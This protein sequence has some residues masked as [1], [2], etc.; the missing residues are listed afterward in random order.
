MCVSCILFSASFPCYFLHHLFR[1]FLSVSLFSWKRI[2]HCC[3]QFI[4]CSEFQVTLRPIC[5]YGAS[6]CVCKCSIFFLFKVAILTSANKKH[7]YKLMAYIYCI[8]RRRWWQ[9]CHTPDIECCYTLLMLLNV[10]PHAKQLREY[11]NMYVFVFANNVSIW[12]EYLTQCAIGN[13]T[14]CWYE[15]NSQIFSFPFWY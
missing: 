10:A 15:S 1:F 2:F 4:L 13:K 3:A 14:L 6:V 7:S 9:R 11:K 8:F 5:V 12:S